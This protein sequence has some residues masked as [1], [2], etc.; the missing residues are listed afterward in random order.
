MRGDA[1]FD[2]V[3]MPMLVEHLC[4]LRCRPAQPLFF[5][6]I[7]VRQRLGK[8]AGAAA[9]DQVRLLRQ[10]DGTAWRFEARAVCLLVITIKLLD[11]IHKDSLVIRPFSTD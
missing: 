2:I 1:F 4:H 8:K 5:A 11:G 7:G 10:V 3:L 9:K 6:Q